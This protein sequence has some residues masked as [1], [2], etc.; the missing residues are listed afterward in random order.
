MIDRST[1]EFVRMWSYKRRALG[2]STLPKV[3]RKVLARTTIHRALMQGYTGSFLLYVE[4]R[5]Q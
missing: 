5:Q 4:E 2:K 3:V 1:F